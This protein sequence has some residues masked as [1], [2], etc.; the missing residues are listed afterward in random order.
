MDII[1][2]VKEYAWIEQ[3]FQAGHLF[4]GPVHVTSRLKVIGKGR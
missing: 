3:L 2:K 4:A 1:K